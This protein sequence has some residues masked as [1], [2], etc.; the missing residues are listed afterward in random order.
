MFKFWSKKKV[1]PP[2]IRELIEKRKNSEV[3]PTDS[4]LIVDDNQVNRDVLSRYLKKYGYT[5]LQADN[6]LETLE[7]CVHEDYHIIWIDLKMPI[8][9]GL[10]T[11]R[12]LRADYPEGFGYK[13]F[14]VGVTGYA[15]DESREQCIKAGMNVVLPKPYVG[16]H[17]FRLH[18]HP[19]FNGTVGTQGT[20]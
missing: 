12:Y 20:C 18:H 13:G 4:E 2:N 11:V 8:M 14:I 10:Q 3:M 5:S 7:R 1:I 16:E 9:D 15:D 19:F 6:G 17:L